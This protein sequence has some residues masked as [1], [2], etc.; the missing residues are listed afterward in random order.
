MFVLITKRQKLFCDKISIPHRTYNYDIYLEG[1][2]T[3]NVWSAV[4]IDEQPSIDMEK[5]VGI[6][7]IYSKEYLNKFVY[8]SIFET[9]RAIA[10][11]NKLKNY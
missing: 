1:K 9:G 3:A 4:E 6:C 10:A 11:S 7:N 2:E 5:H 8:N